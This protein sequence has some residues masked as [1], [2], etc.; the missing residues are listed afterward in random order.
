MWLWQPIK[1]EQRSVKM[2]VQELKKQ[3]DYYNELASRP[4]VD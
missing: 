2:E 1:E 3:Q 4:N